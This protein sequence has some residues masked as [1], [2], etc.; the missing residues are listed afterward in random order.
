LSPKENYERDLPPE[1]ASPAAGGSGAQDRRAFTLG[2]VRPSLHPPL[3]SAQNVK[4]HN[5]SQV[6]RE[7][8][9]LT[10]AQLSQFYKLAKYYDDLNGYK[11]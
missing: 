2:S 6:I 5:P 9:S 3:R 8:V 10:A 4:V 7:G 11:D 1:R